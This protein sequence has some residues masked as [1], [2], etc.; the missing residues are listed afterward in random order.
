MKYVLTNPGVELKDHQRYRLIYD[1]G[2][3]RIFENVDSL[4]RF[5]TARNVVLE[6]RGEHFIRRLIAQTDWRKTGI[7]KMLPVENDQERLDLL[8]PRPV[9]SP[10]ASLVITAA[11]DTDF[12]MRVHAPRYTL[13]VSSQPFWP[14]WRIERN[15]H[16]VDPLPVN[17][18]FLGFTVP[19]GE[20]DVRVH[21]LPMTFYVGLATSL[22][23]IAGLIAFS[24]RWRPGRRRSPARSE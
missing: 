3:G 1:G 17:G 23:T 19:P 12:R 24:W 9:N 8:A 6:F 13:V 15:G 4:P 11:S 14:G 18:A 20:W 2:D 7:V 21:Y 5:F 10:E 16:P 22:I